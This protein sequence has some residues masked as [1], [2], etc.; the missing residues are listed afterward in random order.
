[1][2]LPLSK[3]KKQTIWIYNN[4]FIVNSNKINFWW[5]L[6]NNNI[7]SWYVEVGVLTLRFLIFKVC[8]TSTNRQF[9]KILYQISV[10]HN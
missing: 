1:M 4:N 3:G 2:I 6:Y 7:H 5:I 9:K 10:F 8:V